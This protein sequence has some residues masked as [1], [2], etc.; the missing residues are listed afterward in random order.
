MT[1]LNNHRMVIEIIDMLSEIHKWS[2]HIIKS[3][4]YHISD[5]YIGDSEAPVSIREIPYNGDIKE[6]TKV[7]GPTFISIPIC[8]LFEYI[9]YLPRSPNIVLVFSHDPEVFMY[10][11]QPY[12]QQTVIYMDQL[13]HYLYKYNTRYRPCIKIFSGIIFIAAMIFLVWGLANSPKRK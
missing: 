7:V 8:R 4:A 6:L 3:D 2:D 13:Y 1:T 10:T 12:R 11:Q 5:V 9:A